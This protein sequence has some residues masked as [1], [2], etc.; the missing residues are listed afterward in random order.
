MVRRL[1]FGHQQTQPRPPRDLSPSAD[2]HVHTLPFLL[3]SIFFF[4]KKKRKKEEKVP[5]TTHR[6]LIIGPQNDPIN[7]PEPQEQRVETFFFLLSLSAVLP[8]ENKIRNVWTEPQTSHLHSQSQHNV[9]CKRHRASCSSTSD[10]GLPNCSY[11]A[12]RHSFDF[13]L[14][15][16]CIFTAFKDCVFQSSSSFFLQTRNNKLKRSYS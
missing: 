2:L 5:E 1:Q 16:I 13:S 15:L 4:K 7:R 6:K 3:S 9:L 14:S 12:H 10:T 8:L 11:S